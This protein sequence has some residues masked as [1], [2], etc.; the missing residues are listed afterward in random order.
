MTG[1]RRKT[2]LKHSADYTLQVAIEL[3]RRGQTF[4]E[5]LSL[6]CGKSEIA[7]FAS[8]IAKA[9]EEHIATFRRMRDA[10]PKE[11]CGPILTDEELLAATNELRIKIIPNAKTVREV[12]LASDLRKALDMAIEMEDQAVAFYSE[13][14]SHIA[15]LDA[16]VLRGVVNEEMEHL[17]MLREMRNLLSA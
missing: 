4:Y 15:N 17:R 10:L 3:E 11:L 5:S 6:A 9:E 7:A 1:G 8:S 2:T 13:L 14:A 16:A 12:V